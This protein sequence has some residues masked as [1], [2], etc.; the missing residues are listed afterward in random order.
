MTEMVKIPPAVQ[1]A[2]APSLG[3]EDLLEKGTAT[4]RSILAWRIL[5][6]E[7]TGGPEGHKESDTTERRTLSLHFTDA[8]RFG[9][10]VTDSK[11]VPGG[12]A[13]LNSISASSQKLCV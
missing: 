7:E 1:G 6:T 10:V 9:D 13:F 2:R 12:T 4:H 11:E 3:Q 5:W 8:G